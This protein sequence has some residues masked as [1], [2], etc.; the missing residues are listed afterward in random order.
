[1]AILSEQPYELNSILE[2]Y[3]V[4]IGLWNFSP[5]DYFDWCRQH[6]QCHADDYTPGA[7]DH[8]MCNV[9]KTQL[10]EVYAT[11]PFDAQWYTSFHATFVTALAK[12]WELDMGSMQVDIKQ[13]YCRSLNMNGSYGC[14][15]QM[16][17]I[18]G[19]M[20]PGS[21]VPNAK[22]CIIKFEPKFD[23]IDDWVR[24]ITRTG[25][26]GYIIAGPQ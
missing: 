5:M 10:A 15:P 24:L 19:H 1:M 20:L 13:R 16:I 3:G 11:G 8:L 18:T 9:L 22:Q 4:T 7:A 6:E 23:H 26:N 25:K 12:C 2:W 14:A 21:K 17:T